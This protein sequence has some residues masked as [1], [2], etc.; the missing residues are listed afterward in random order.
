VVYTW[1]ASSHV[2]REVVTPLNAD[3]LTE[4]TAAM[5]QAVGYRSSDGTLW[6]LPGGGGGSGAELF[7]VTISVSGNVY[8]ASE[9]V[10]DI[11]TAY[12]SGKLVKYYNEVGAEGLLF[13]TPTA[14]GITFVCFDDADGGHPTMMTIYSIAA[15]GS[16][17]VSS[18]NILNSLIQPGSQTRTAAQMASGLLAIPN[19]IY[20]VTGDATGFV[21]TNSTN[22]ITTPGECIEIRLAVGSTAIT[23]PTWPSWCNLMNG[24]DGTFAASTYY[25]IVIDDAGNVYAGTREVTA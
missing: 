24:W 12:Q 13:A 9:T 16:V 5:T 1:S 8:S 22:P 2:A 3:L 25:D 19:V 10:A 17:T 20:T 14:Y 6:T 4:K 18:E 7:E 21:L 11:M 23:T 15:D